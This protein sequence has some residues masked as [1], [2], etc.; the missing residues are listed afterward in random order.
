M[1]AL[2]R[3]ALEGKAVPVHFRCVP[4]FTLKLI[5]KVHRRSALEP[6][7]TPLNIRVTRDPEYR[8]PG[9]SGGPGY[10]GSRLP[11]SCNIRGPGIS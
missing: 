9:I 8:D 7:S 6:R 3:S 4:S 11:G 10:P 5:R 2:S 1:Y